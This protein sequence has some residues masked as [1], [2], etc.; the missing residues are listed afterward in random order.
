M[1]VKV[2]GIHSP[3][4]GVTKLRCGLLSKFFDHLLRL[5]TTENFNQLIEVAV[6]FAPGT[7]Y[8]YHR[9]CMYVCLFVCLSVCLSARIYLNHI[10]KFYQIFLYVLNVAVDRSF[11]NGDAIC[12]VLPVAWMTSYFT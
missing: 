4:L 11:S 3:P 12:Y 8:C 2:G 6:C 5:V 7:K 10:S 1:G 9:V